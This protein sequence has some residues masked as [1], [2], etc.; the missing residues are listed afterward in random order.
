MS[1]KVNLLPRELAADRAARRITG[2]TVGVVLL[3]VVLLGFLYMAK[4]NEIAQAEDERDAAQ[5]EVSRLQAE[6][7]QLEQ[8]RQLANEF[9][10]RNALLASAMGNEVS[11]ARALNDL[12]LAFPATSSL[13]GMT[14]TAAD[15]AAVA[16]QAA[17]VDFGEAVATT[18]FEGYSTE[19]FAPGVET[20]LVE[21]DKVATFF[22]TFLTTAQLEEIGTTEVTTFNG[23]LQLDE[24][25]LTRRYEDGLPEES[26]Q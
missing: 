8:F 13:R 16:P 2:I 5:A 4:L 24:D 1:V 9:E 21:F 19:R 18:T 12:S 25:A 3:F 17:T 26:S 14:M 7:A 10:A 15:P 11:F 20:V 23:S 6:I 22:N